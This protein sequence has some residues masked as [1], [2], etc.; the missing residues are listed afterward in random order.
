MRRVVHHP[1]H[2]RAVGLVAQDRRR[3]E[4]L[5]RGAH[6]EPL[7]RPVGHGPP[8]ADVARVHAEPGAVAPLQLG[9]FGASGGRLGV[10]GGGG[11][12]RGQRGGGHGGAGER[13]AGLDQAAARQPDGAVGVGHE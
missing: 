8:G 10:R 2:R 11:G 13:E 12:G 4:R 9:Q 6:R 5:E 3:G 1:V 7:P